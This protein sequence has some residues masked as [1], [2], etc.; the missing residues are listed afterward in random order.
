[1]KKQKLRKNGF[2]MILVIFAFSAVALWMSILAFNSRILLFQADR[3]YLDACRQNLV[4]SGLNW[5]GQN[6]DSLRTTAGV[7]LD[8]ADMNIKGASL[9]VTIISA[10][11][12][13][14]QVEIKTS[15]SK[16]E[17]TIKSSEKL[18]VKTRP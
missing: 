3:A 7:E 4:E 5:S 17:Q 12:K 18:F 1:M 15:C 2:V 9:H 13:A 10:K 14:A 6:G 11:R 16:G 8:T